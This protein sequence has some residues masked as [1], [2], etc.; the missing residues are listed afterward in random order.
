[1][2]DLPQLIP[3]TEWLWVAWQELASRRQRYPQPQPIQIT[4][5][6]AYASYLGLFG[7][8]DHDL[9]LGVIGALD[10]FYIETWER[11]AANARKKQEQ[12]QRSRQRQ[13]SRRRRR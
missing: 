1:M 10:K 12:A 5:I 8:S 2:L 11:E 3:G 6:N 13:Q 7:S 4:E 9:L